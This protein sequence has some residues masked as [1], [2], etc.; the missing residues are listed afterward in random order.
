[1][2]SGKIVNFGVPI[3]CGLLLTVMVGLTFLQVV[4][5]NCFDS[6][7]NWSDEV[8]QFCMTW[9]VLFGSI[10][11]SKNNLHLNTGLK[12]HQKL[13]K[14]L[15]CLIDSIL[16]LALIIVGTVVAYQTA[17]FAF[18]ALGTESLSLPGVKMGYIFIAMPIAML[19]LC[20]Y[21]LKGFFKNLAGI[22][23]KN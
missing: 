19:G 17:M 6:S 4:L 9:M 13:N 21:S 18:M 11:A 3:L 22:F 2:K 5:R 14:R 7:M 20:Y 1:M 23:K 15:I 8:S 10:W 16:D 12:L